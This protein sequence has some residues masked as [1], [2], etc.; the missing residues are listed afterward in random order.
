PW[1]V[2][3]LLRTARSIADP[4]GLVKAY[5]YPEGRDF[6]KMVPIAPACVEN[7]FTRKKTKSKCYRKAIREHQHQMATYQRSVLVKRQCAWEEFQDWLS[8][9]EEGEDHFPFKQFS[10]YDRFPVD[11]FLWKDM[12]QNLLYQ[13]HDL[14]K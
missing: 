9:M 3:S 11:V 10:L 1:Y 6:L 12:P 14:N 2:E 13:T 7:R 5:G 4:S 8:D